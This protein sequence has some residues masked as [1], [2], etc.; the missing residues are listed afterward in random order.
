MENTQPLPVGKIFDLGGLQA[1]VIAM[2]GHTPGSVGLLV[3]DHGVLLVGDAANAHVW[4]FLDE[5]LPVRDYIAMLKRVVGYEFDTFLTAHNNG[6][7]HPKSEMLKY[8]ET[9]ENAS[10]EKA[11]PYDGPMGLKGFLY[12]EDGIGIVVSERTLGGKA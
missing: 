10:L 5:S 12:Q 6:K 3:K 7:I 11:E 2:E 9:A 1:E 8:I 4:M